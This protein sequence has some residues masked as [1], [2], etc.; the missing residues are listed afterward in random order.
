[1][2]NCSERNSMN[3]FGTIIV[4]QTTAADSTHFLDNAAA[5]KLQRW[6]ALLVRPVESE[7]TKIRPYGLLEESAWREWLGRMQ[8]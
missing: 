8:A 7:S 4:Y 3:E 6:Q 5:T 1:M 2:Q